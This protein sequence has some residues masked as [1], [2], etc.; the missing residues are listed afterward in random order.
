[1]MRYQPAPFGKAFLAI[2]GLFPFALS[3]PG[4]TIG[5]LSGF[6]A[7]GPAH[8][9]SH[10]PVVTSDSPEYCDVLLSRISGI[11]RASTV[12]PPTEVALLSQEG[13]RMCVHGQ[14]RGGILRLRRALEIMRHGDD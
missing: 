11:R 3:V 5:G 7:F 12:P 2:L 6:A 10:D 9:Q 14:T 4:T 8:A 1:M 13:A